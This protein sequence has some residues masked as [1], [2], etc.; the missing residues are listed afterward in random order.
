MQITQHGKLVDAATGEVVE[1]VDG[2]RDLI[3][4]NREDPIAELIRNSGSVPI[5][6]QKARE[7]GVPAPIVSSYIGN[8][9]D[10]ANQHLNRRIE[11]TGAIVYFSGRFTPKDPSQHDGSGFYCFLLKTSDTR[12]MEYRDG[13]VVKEIETP[14]IIKTDGVKLRDTIINL[15]DTWGWFD[16]DVKV[17][18]VITR[19]GPNNEFYIQVLP[20]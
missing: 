11:L 19:G 1:D 3:L 8:A 5:H 20:E 9:A 4:E 10:S 12:K 15:I 18:V 13:K 14:V 6:V 16:W 7:L 2:V 17:P